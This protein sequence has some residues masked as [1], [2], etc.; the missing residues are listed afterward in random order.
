MAA[1]RE[2]SLDLSTNEEDYRKEMI[3]QSNDQKKAK[4]YL[5]DIAESPRNN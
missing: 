3:N 2:Q 5:D 4:K 1:S